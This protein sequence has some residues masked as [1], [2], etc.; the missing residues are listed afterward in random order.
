MTIA[1]QKAYRHA[2]R[3][4]KLRMQAI[5]WDKNVYHKV[6]ARY[7]QAVSAAEEYKLLEDALAFFEKLLPKKRK[8]AQPQPAELRYE[9]LNE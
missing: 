3:L 5:G 1:E 9:D 4:I 8:A 6:G 7:P 2:V